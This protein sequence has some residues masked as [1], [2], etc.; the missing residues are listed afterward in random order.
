MHRQENTLEC[1]YHGWQFGPDGRATVIPQVWLP[2]K[3]AA[4]SISTTLCRLH[5]VF[6]AVLRMAGLHSSCACA[7]GICGDLCLHGDEMRVAVLP[8]GWL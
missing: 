8:A 7:M 5:C 4:G 1:A 3:K 6:A 2:D